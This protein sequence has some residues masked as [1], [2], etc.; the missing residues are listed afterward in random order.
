MTYEQGYCGYT[1]YETWAVSLW[2]DNDEGMQNILIDLVNE[3]DDVPH[4]LVAEKG[5]SETV[6]AT[7]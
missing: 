1:N 7:P 6:A 4:L 2:I 3:A 5:K